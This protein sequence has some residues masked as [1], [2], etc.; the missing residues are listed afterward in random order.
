MRNRVSILRTAMAWSSLAS[1]LALTS[2]AGAHQQPLKIGAT[3]SN[4]GAYATQGQAAGQGYQ[5]CVQHLN[6]QGGILGR[7]VVLTLHDDGSD[8]AQARTLYRQL[9]EDEHVDLILGPYGSTLTEAIADITEQHR[10]VQITP[11]AATS[12]IWQQGR[13]YLFMVLPPAEMFLAGLIDLA[14]ERELSRVAIIHEDALFPA[15]AAHGAQNLAVERGLDVRLFQ[16]Y[17]SGEGDFDAMA[18]ALAAQDIEVLAMAA[19]NLTNFIDMQRALKAHNVELAM[20]G[21]SGAVQQFSDELGAD[22]EGVFGLSAWEPA[23]P[24][25]G[26][27]EFTA[28]YTEAYGRAPAFHSA[29]AYASCQLLAA[30][31]EEVGS[32][33]QDALREALLATDTTT[34]FGRFAVDERGYQTAHEGLFIQWQDAQKVIVWPA[35]VAERP[36]R[37]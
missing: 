17:P 37:W 35:S 7:E 28:A 20:F 33:D 32:T 14:A 8:S 16:H 18:Q 9:I 34:V 30:A 22:A 24:N 27:A 25:P 21:T 19:S 36:V 26:A 3:M 23:A 11:L 15:A 13:Q 10:M 29:G 6:Q 12:S 5:L 2:V 31:V 4:S 1:A